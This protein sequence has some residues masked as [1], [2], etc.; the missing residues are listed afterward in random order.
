M[1]RYIQTDAEN[2]L[3]GK[4]ERLL[5]IGKRLSFLLTES[6][7]SLIDSTSMKTKSQLI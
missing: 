7:D 5:F 6:P 2:I 4:N 3:P 1:L